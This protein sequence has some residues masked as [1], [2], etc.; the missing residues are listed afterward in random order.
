M[1][2]VR[3]VGYLVPLGKEQAPGQ[4]V[5]CGLLLLGGGVCL[6]RVCF[7]KWTES[8]SVSSLNLSPVTTGVD[9]SG[10]KDKE[11]QLIKSRPMAGW[12]I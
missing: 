8:L 6:L 7:R 5:G 11:R 9:P 3:P 2:A 12:L 10:T 4:A 1:C